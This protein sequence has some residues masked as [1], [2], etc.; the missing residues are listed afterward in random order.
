MY[1]LEGESSVANLNTAMKSQ[2]KRDIH[3]LSVI[4]SML[5]KATF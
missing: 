1:T 5:P 4:C 3:F 2:K